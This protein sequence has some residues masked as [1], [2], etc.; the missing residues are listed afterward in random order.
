MVL[1]VWFRGPARWTQPTWVLLGVGALFG[2]L[3]LANTGPA[4]A[5]GTVCGLIC[6]AVFGAVVSI[7]A[8]RCAVES[9]IDHLV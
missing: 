8:R 7:S 9:P 6:A 4:L 3:M 5:I 2:Y 1:S